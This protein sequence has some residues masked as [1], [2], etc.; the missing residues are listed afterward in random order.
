MTYRFLPWSR[1]GLAASIATPDTGDASTSEVAAF[2]V[3]VRLNDAAPITTRLRINGP[4]DVTGIDSRVII[5]TDPERYV[6]DF[7]PNNLVSIEF[8]QPD[9]PWMFTPAAADAQERLRPWLVLVVVEDRKGVTIGV[10][11]DSPLPTLTISSPAGAADE[12]PDLAESWAWAHTQL[13][14]EQDDA[15]QI[16]DEVEHGHDLNLSRLICPRR[17]VPGRRYFACLVPAFEVGRVA[18]LGGEP[19]EGLGLAPAWRRDDS[20]VTLPLYFHW[21]FGTSNG[22]SDFEDLVDRL[23]AREVPE[24]A[25]TLPMFV[26]AA[27][28]G[29]GQLTPDE[30][31]AVLGMEGAL[32]PLSLSEPSLDDVSQPMVDDLRARLN[33][34][35]EHLAAGTP[36]GGPPIGPPLYGSYHIATHELGQPDGVAWF[37]E[38]NVDPRLRTAAAVGTSIVQTHQEELMDEAWAQVGDVIAANEAINRAALSNAAA[39]S[40]FRRHIVPLSEDGVFAITAPSHTRVVMSGGTVRR[41]VAKSRIPDA[42]VDPAFRRASS[43]QNR[44]LK[45]AARRTGADVDRN[46]AVRVD[47]V[48]RID[49]GTLT[50]DDLGTA[51]DGVVRTLALEELDTTGSTVDMTPIGGVGSVA[52]QLV[53]A[54]NEETAGLPGD[55]ADPPLR[56]R[57]GLTA[58]GLLTHDHVLGVKSALGRDTSQLAARVI[59]AVANHRA[60]PGS[61]GIV[62]VKRG[63]ALVPVT[64]GPNSTGPIL[65]LPN[66]SSTTIRSFGS[67]LREFSTAFEADLP[68][69]QQPSLG[70]TDLRTRLLAANEPGR[71]AVRR[72]ASR[73]HRGGHEAD[74]PFDPIM[75]GPKFVAPLHEALAEKSP[76]HFLPGI[77]AIEPNSFVVVETN[78]RF[79]ESFLVG[80]NHEMNHELLWREYPTD[81]RGTPFRH[82]WGRADIGPDI[83]PIH[84]WDRTTSIGGNLLGGPG[85]PI[86]LLIR[87]ELLHH[88]PNTVI[89]AAPGLAGSFALDTDPAHRKDPIVIGRLPPDVTFVMLPI[90]KD[91]LIADPG[92]YIVFQEQPTELRFGLDRAS[93]GQP[94]IGDLTVWDDLTWGHADTFEGE[95]LR[96]AGN[97]LASV[98]II[99]G[100]QFGRNSSD[101]ARILLQRPVMV[102][103]HADALLGDLA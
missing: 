37:D 69:N 16:A 29:I 5:R 6:A 57:K 72:L 88:Y 9:L 27:G 77:G 44:I 53:R 87:A 59:A 64:P 36:D 63:D 32:R 17:L 48:G 25:G 79:V 40:A 103:F 84:R 49:D 20:A 43:P 12:L 46:G 60:P 22:G 90:T 4:G 66:R 2:T 92:Y 28:D 19:T 50:L 3:G 31:G 41:A 81:R 99:E 96:I 70:L 38:L 97:P 24:G 33:A 51:P 71:V 47:I 75:A 39:S 83:D 65:P 18:G 8:D 30:P 10:R 76:D 23:E 13:I 80:A 1:R 100:A 86:V 67:A 95:H 58:G 14:T 42:T 52:G 55:G 62:L 94:D 101:F 7:E 26:G 93:A 34:S 21:E 98:P 91:E 78:P 82:F 11:S 61:R 68:I 45:R 35:S 102:A 74:D 73:V 54:V 89:Y 15:D 56:P 85:N